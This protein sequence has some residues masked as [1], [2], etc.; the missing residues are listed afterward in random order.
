MQ[1]RVEGSWPWP[2]ALHATAHAHPAS[3]R[4]HESNRAA[5][6]A[7]VAPPMDIVLSGMPVDGRSNAVD[8]I[9]PHVRRS[10][11]GFGPA[12]HLDVISCWKGVT[13]AQACELASWDCFFKECLA[14]Q[15]K[16]YLQCEFLNSLSGPSSE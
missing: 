16:E 8:F 4:S 3:A 12:Q 10:P 1:T 6:K 7:P 14:V 13:Y 15:I 11:L 2:D 5:S 9:V